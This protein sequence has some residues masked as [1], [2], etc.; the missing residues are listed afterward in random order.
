MAE[1]VYYS[2]MSD[3]LA[4]ILS[5]K[6]FDEPEESLAIKSFVLEKYGK[7]VA[8]TVREKDIIVTAQ[9]AAFAGALRAQSRALQRAADTHKRLIFR[10][11]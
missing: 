2:K 11:A 6:N 4:D 5:R 7:S 8:V 3:S 10:I 1:A 9:G